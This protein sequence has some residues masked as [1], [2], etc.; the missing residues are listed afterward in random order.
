MRTPSAYIDMQKVFTADRVFSGSDWLPDHAVVVEKGIIKDILPLVS[1]PSESV[2]EEH[3]YIITP[4][5]IDAQI[6]GASGK[7]FATF[8]TAETLQLMQEN[9]ALAGTHYFLPT[10]ATNTYDVFK[11]CIDAVKEYWNQGGV[12]VGGLHIEGPWI[13]KNKRGAHVENL[14][15]TPTINQVHELLDYG[16]GVIKMITLAPEICNKEMIRLIRSKKVLVSAGHSDATFEQAT[17]SFDNGVY[18]VTHLFNAMSPLHHRSPGMPAAV[19]QHPQVV[20]S[21]IADGHHVDFEMISIAK[22]LLEDRLF[23][24]TDAV[25][26]TTEG[27]YQHKLEGDK[28]VCNGILSGSALTMLQAVKNCIDKVGI[29]EEEALRMATVYPARILGIDD[30]LG[31]IK[32]GHRAE[33]T[34][35]DKDW[36]VHNFHLPQRHEDT[37]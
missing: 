28:Y 32:K 27:L 31:M 9:C 20:A 37:K 17:E 23:L 8:P 13:N 36:R 10:V 34:F 33:L 4:S 12:G 22:K 2:I 3:V 15:H 7:L 1:L 5:F 25:T 29:K 14:I 16:M 30:E 21:I 19:I 11:R 24:I 6:Y 18:A 26:E 35:L